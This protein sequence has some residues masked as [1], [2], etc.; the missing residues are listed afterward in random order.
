MIQGNTKSNKTV[1]ISVEEFGTFFK[2][3]NVQ[4]EAEITNIRLENENKNPY[5]ELNKPF[6]ENEL[7]K[8]LKI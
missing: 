6:S 5:E 8:A 1:D 2:N 3:L 7:K 4:E